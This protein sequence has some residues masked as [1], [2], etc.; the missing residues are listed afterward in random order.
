MIFLVNM[1]SNPNCSYPTD[2]GN[3]GQL[4]EHTGAKHKSSRN[5]IL[6]IP[7][8]HVQQCRQGKKGYLPYP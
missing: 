7:L 2:F 1:K 4:G 8:S 5:A 6:R 3:N